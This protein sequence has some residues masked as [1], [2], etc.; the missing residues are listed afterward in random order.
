MAMDRMLHDLAARGLLVV[1]PV[2]HEHINEDE[3]NVYATDDGDFSNVR[4][5]TYLLATPAPGGR[6]AVILGVVTTPIGQDAFIRALPPITKNDK[7]IEL[8]SPDALGHD[9]SELPFS[10]WVVDTE[11]GHEGWERHPTLPDPDGTQATDSAG[12]SDE[13]LQKLLGGLGES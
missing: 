12:P 4:K 7:V 9:Y 10:L 6:F 1:V 11:G 13:W 5:S 2:H 8:A 3:S